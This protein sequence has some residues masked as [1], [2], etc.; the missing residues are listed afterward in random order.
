M[1][2]ED[3]SLLDD[4]PIE[5]KGGTLTLSTEDD[6]DELTFLNREGSSTSFSLCLHKIRMCNVIVHTRSI[7]ELYQPKK[8]FPLISTL[9]LLYLLHI[10]KKCTKIC[11]P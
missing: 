11:V 9:S 3:D 2:K 7:W 1:L 8:C 10:N 5:F 6:T 4:E